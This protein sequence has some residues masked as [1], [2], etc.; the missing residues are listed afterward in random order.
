MITTA[1]LRSLALFEKVT[2][3]ELQDLLARGDEVV[4][5]AGDELWAQG[6]GAD[7]WWVVLEG[8][9]DLVRLAGHEETRVGTM[10]QPGQW[11]GGFTAWDEHAVYL[12]NGRASTNG[13]ALRV[14]STDLKEWTGALDPF[15]SHLIEGVFRTARTVESAARQ[16]DALVA[17]GTLSAGLA[18]ELNNPAAAAARAVDALNG[19][20]GRLLDT[21]TDLATNDVTAS[22]FGALDAL[23]REL[24]ATS[25]DPLSPVALADREDEL[26]SWLDDHGVVDGWQIAGTLAAAGIDTSWCDRVAQVLDGS[27]AAGLA[28]VTSTLSVSN[29]LAEVKESTRRISELV[30]AIKSYSQMDRASVQQTVISEGLE[31][32]LVVLRH[33]MPSGV[34]VVRDYAPD[35]PPIAAIPAELNQVWTNLI[36]N[37][38]DAMDGAGTLRLSIRPER[39]GVVVAVANTGN[40]SDAG[41]RERAF[42]PFFTTKGVGQGTGLGLDISRRIIVGRHGGEISIEQPPGETVLRVWLPRQAT[43]AQ[44]G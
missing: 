6:G 37:A 8:H 7:S 16:R 36:T 25:G 38:L 5:E 12:A 32:T 11:A 35:T 3:E 39:D 28:W 30:G 29:L 15:G 26:A 10:A 44:R 24:V 40:W 19:A 21:L 1:E 2:E 43:E 9:V 14:S 31:S 42:E 18:H 17:L 27:P 41:S 4:F 20:S 23:R 34:T 22:Q 33:R 13:R